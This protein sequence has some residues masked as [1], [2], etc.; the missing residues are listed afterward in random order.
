MSSNHLPSRLFFTIV[1]VF[2]LGSLSCAQTGV[3]NIYVSTY[4]PSANVKIDG[5]SYG[6]APLLIENLTAGAHS[7]LISFPGYMPLNINAYVVAGQSINV[8]GYLDKPGARLVVSSSP[9]GASVYVDGVLK[10]G[11]KLQI[12]DLAQGSHNVRVTLLGYAPAN[13]TVTLSNMSV[14]YIYFPLE[15]LK[16]GI[17]VSSLPSG[18]D[19]Q[20]N[21]ILQGQTSLYAPN[22]EAG[23]YFVNVTKTGY[24][25]Y[26]ENVT[27]DPGTAAYVYAQLVP[28]SGGSLECLP[29]QLI[30][31]VDG[32]GDVTSHDANLT[33]KVTVGLIP[34]PSNLC[35]IDLSGDGYVSGLDAVLI[36]RIAEGIDPRRGP[37]GVICLPG[38]LIGDVDGSGAVTSHDANLTAKVT[39]GLIPAPSNL[40]CIDLSGDG[41]VSGL[42]AV[43]I[44]RIAEGMA[45][46]RGPCTSNG[47]L[48]VNSNP[49]SARILLN[50]VD[51]GYTY[52]SF[53]IPAGTYNLT[54]VKPGYYDY[55]KN[56]IITGGQTTTENAVLVLMPSGTVI[57]DS[58]PQGASVTLDGASSGVTPV[59]LYD[60]AAGTHPLLLTK[61]GY[62][63]YSANVTTGSGVTVRN[64]TLES[65]G[66]GSLSVSSNP[67]N[68]FIYLDGV[69]V[70]MTL[71]LLSGLSAGQHNLTVRKTGYSDYVG[72]VTVYPGQTTTVYVDFY[73]LPATGTLKIDSVPQGASITLDGASSGVTP[74][75][76]YDVAAGTHPLLLTK[77]GYSNYNENW[78]TST[79]M[80]LRNVTLTPM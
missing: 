49:P 37:C 56:I 5:V 9:S 71:R 55:T 79:G 7:V 32:S 1:A 43:L 11:T 42:D 59:T 50:G 60:V 69:G 75:T 73:S 22:L 35:C 61:S 17:Y 36:S 27:V 8:Y 16:G 34:A 2:C 26:V 29:G 15:P 30:G 63:S 3:G 77:S 54:L 18:A 51:Y 57:V 70:G 53:Q 6:S 21:G 65:L 20:I 62:S 19:V 52:R 48:N 64:I 38:Q 76:L 40:C 25:P 12:L 74:V 41:Y 39:V 24:L 13:R 58:V 47:T 78:V 14:K 45:P 10:G 33:A 23:N 66:P 68:A 4:P 46:G 31:D 72:V 44:S 28:I 67:S 80:N